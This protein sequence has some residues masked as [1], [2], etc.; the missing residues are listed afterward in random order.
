MKKYINIKLTAITWHVFI[1]FFF[2]AFISIINEFILSDT[3]KTIHSILKIFNFPLY[4]LT[5]VSIIVSVYYAFKY[6]TKRNTICLVY[7]FLVLL[8]EILVIRGLYRYLEVFN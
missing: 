8:L 4:L 3:L 5:L 6:Q 2:S 1:L 7:S